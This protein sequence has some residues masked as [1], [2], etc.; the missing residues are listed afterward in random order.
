MEQIAT[1]DVSGVTV[2]AKLGSLYKAIGSVKK[3]EGWAQNIT[4]SNSSS[5]GT[6]IYAIED[7]TDPNHAGW[8]MWRIDGESLGLD[9]RAKTADSPDS[10]VKVNFAGKPVFIKEWG[11]VEDGCII[12]YTPTVP[13]SDIF[14]SSIHVTNQISD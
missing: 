14:I 11:D 13:D 8:K 3:S 10:E 6:K 4:L 12:L 5:S 9:F 1:N 2:F 7:S